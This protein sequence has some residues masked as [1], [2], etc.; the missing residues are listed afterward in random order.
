MSLRGVSNR[1]RSNGFVNK[2]ANFYSV[3][4]LQPYA[5]ILVTLTYKVKTAL[6]R[7]S[8]DYETGFFASFTA[9]ALSTYNVGTSLPFPLSFPSRIFS[10]NSSLAPSLAA[11][12][13]VS[14]DNVTDRCSWLDHA[15]ALP[16]YPATAPLF[17]RL[18][19]TSSAKSASPNASN[20]PLLLPAPY[21]KPQLLV[22]RKYLRIRS[23]S[24]Q[25]ASVGRS[26]VRAARDTANAV[27]TCSLGT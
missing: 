26:I 20:T 23:T 19:L 7:V 6:Q 17:D 9:L 8:A 25:S 27:W 24:V 16:A 12:N 15:I 22:P 2:S 11:I 5:T 3:S 13:S 21:S 4:V 14:V 1:T 18:V 10:Q